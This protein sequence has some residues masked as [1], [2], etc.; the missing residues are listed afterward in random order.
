MLRD[1][2]EALESLLR[3]E[4]PQE[5]QERVT[6][7]FAAP[8]AEFPPQ[9]VTLPAIDVFLYDI[10]ENRQLRTGQHTRTF[11][12]DDRL[13]EAPAPTWINCGYLITAWASG[14][15]LHA[16]RDQHHLL[17]LILDVLLRHPTLPDPFLKGALRES[18]LPV[19][20]LV[21]HK[22]SLPGVTE[23]WQALGGKPKASLGLTVTVGVFPKLS[24]RT[25]P[26]VKERDFII[27]PNTPAL[28][29][30]TTPS[31]SSVR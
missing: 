26:P 27:G 23:L 1:L 20:L 5:L 11:E 14:S 2:D 31:H 21:L 6:L 24:E 7:S 19:R 13:V 17:G 12:R 3:S 25:F 30:T 15:S 28:P 8:D 16:A 10:H 18:E 4:L 22:E 29:A 9:G